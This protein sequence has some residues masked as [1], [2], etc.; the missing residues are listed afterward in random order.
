MR[1]KKANYRILLL[2]M[3]LLVPAAPGFAQQVAPMQKGRPA[4]NQAGY[5][6]GEAKRFTVPG[7]PDGSSFY[8]Y[9]AADTLKDSPE[10][11]YSGTVKGYAGYFSDFRPADPSAE[12]VV[13][14]PGQ[15][16][17]VPFRI[18]PY[19]MENLS[20]RL[21]YQFFIDVRGG[22][23]TDLSPA[24][25][26]GGGPSRDGGGSVMEATFE[27][28]LYA[29]NP[30][31]FDRW[32]NELKYY[33]GNRMWADLPP[34]E[35]NNYRVY[36]TTQ[37]STVTDPAQTPDLIKLLLW[38]A[39]FAYKHL[40]YNGIAGGGFNDWLSYN[41]VRMFGYE[42]DSLQ[43]FDY[44][45]MLDQLAAVCAYYHLFL[46]PYMSEETYH[47]YRQACLD[48]WE[49]Y[50]RQKEVRYWVKSFKWID[51]GYR[52]FNEQ[53][54]AFG[55]GLLRNL[56][57]YICELH[58][59]GGEAGKFLG[60]AQQ[61]AADIVENWDFNNP[62]HMWSMRNAEHITPQALAVFYLM[63]PDKAPP[64]TLRKLEDYR[65]YVLERTD[66]LWQYRTHSDREWAH[67]K[68][69][70]VGT[71]AGLAGSFF[72]VAKALED[73]KL[74]EVGWSQVNFVFGCNPAYA[75]LS[76][77][78]AAR[79]ALK[80][81]WEGVE[82]GWPHPYVHGT[83]ELGLCRGTLDGSPTNHAF[84]FHPDSAALADMPGIY[85][86]EGWSHTNRAWMSSVA[87]STIGSHEVRIL[88]SSGAPVSSAKAGGEVILEL[89][90]ALDQREDQVEKGWV[91]VEAGDLQEKVVVTETG[92]GTGVFQ[93][94]YR[95]PSHK[96]EK[97]SVSYGYL[98]FRK[99]VALTI[100]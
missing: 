29:S 83:G 19:L 28:L 45:N 51:E 17:S 48:N 3:T 78:S 89:D 20:S 84:P 22:Y 100:R 32:T 12:F 31:L 81:Y 40:A 5:N 88:S 26:T 49:A 53:G 95:L 13:A 27:G 55:Q 85:G 76:N 65:D 39:E 97:L 52:E 73:E 44:Q 75:H 86:T 30:A 71:V 35:E 10:A 46:K 59:P 74:R 77:K 61:C 23:K 94:A 9:R 16:H 54:N 18:A 64:G 25:V 34:P 79:V 11:L 66:N 50:D 87:F 57:M 82:T 92:P 67:P 93:A 21:A 38:H 47:K 8:I 80:G 1:K 42:G 43:S 60:Y 63:F 58:E 69:K 91:L 37:D 24:N 62:W 72:A 68:S 15:G 98:P 14:V 56:F 36:K 4:V 2:S 7:A 70:E 33:E 6:L 99:S 41:K 90:A 96:G